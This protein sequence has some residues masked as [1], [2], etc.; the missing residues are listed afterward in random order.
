MRNLVLGAIFQLL[1]TRLGFLH[2]A[3]GR[4]AYGPAWAGRRQHVIPVDRHGTLL[5]IGCGEGRLL[6]TFDTKPF[7]ALG[8]E[9]SRVMA[10][11]AA[12]HG[13][14]V[15]RAT[16]QSLPLRDGAISHV[17]ATYPGPWIVDRQTWDEIARVA[18]PGASI[19]IVLGG[20]VVRGRGSFVRSRLLR[21]AYGSSSAEMSM[22]ELGH[23]QIVGSYVE[24]TDDWGTAILWSGTRT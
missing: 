10:R 6:R 4:I 12:N 14:I 9:P 21:L 5:D 8:V 19:Q 16:S 17:I 2:E 22:P 20:D 23:P 15:L 18:A 13:V 11:R 3:A 7:V 24:T 1:Y